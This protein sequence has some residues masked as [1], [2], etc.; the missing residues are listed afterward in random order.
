[1][2]R[3]STDAWSWLAE[4]EAKAAP[5]N[6]EMNGVIGKR[7]KEESLMIVAALGQEPRLGRW[8]TVKGNGA[9]N[10]SRVFVLHQK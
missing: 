8:M 3:A 10:G 1:M 4:K 2:P 5:E 9:A 7:K 6:S